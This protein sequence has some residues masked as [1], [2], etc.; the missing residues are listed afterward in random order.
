MQREEEHTRR[1]G[2]IQT[3]AY[4]VEHIFTMYAL[5]RHASGAIDATSFYRMDRL[6]N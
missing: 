2:H 3:Y 1:N 4:R 6:A 5:T